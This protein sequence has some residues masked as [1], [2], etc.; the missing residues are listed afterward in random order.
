ML[1]KN[2][3]KLGVEIFFFKIP[4]GRTIF[5][6]SCKTSGFCGAGCFFGGIFLSFFGHFF[7][8]NFSCCGAGCSFWYLFCHFF[9]QN[10]IFL[11]GW[12]VFLSK[13]N[14]FFWYLASA[15][16][17][18]ALTRIAKAVSHKPSVCQAFS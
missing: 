14:T 18:R 6:F 17:A 11:R 4:I 16:S 3:V 2:L 8:Q 9:M 13:K 12:E 15:R 1:F 5:N 10:F 7:L